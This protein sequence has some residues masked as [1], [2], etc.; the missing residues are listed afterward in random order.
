M[1]LIAWRRVGA[2]LQLLW[3]LSANA[4]GY[5][6]G[7]VGSVVGGLAWAVA[8]AFVIGR[9][10]WS[11]I[12]LTAIVALLGGGAIAR[13]GERARLIVSARLARVRTPYCFGKTPSRTSSANRAETVP[14]HDTAEP[15]TSTA[16]PRP[17]RASIR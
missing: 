15:S 5:Y 12:P 6:G 10:I 8:S 3:M 14:G 4:G 2:R 9:P 17:A 1:E 13:T 16:P 11:L 7:L